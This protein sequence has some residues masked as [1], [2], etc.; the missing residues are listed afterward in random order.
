MRMKTSALS[1]LAAAIVC[2]CSPS[3]H[4]KAVHGY[5]A[6]HHHEAITRKRTAAVAAS[7]SPPVMS[8]HTANALRSA[9]IH[10]LFWGHSWHDTAAE[11]T[12]K[13][14]QG[15]LSEIVRSSYITQ[16]SN[17]D[18]DARVQIAPA[19]LVSSNTCS[20]P[21][22]AEGTIY[23]QNPPIEIPE[24]VIAPCIDENH[25]SVSHDD[26]FVLLLP[27]NVY[28]LNDVN[29]G[30]HL[31]YDRNLPNGE[32]ETFAYATIAWHKARGEG[33][34]S[35]SDTITH[36]TLEAITDPYQ[37]TIY[38]H[39]GDDPDDCDK[40]DDSPTC[41]IADVCESYP[42]AVSGTGVNYARWWDQRSSQCVVTAPSAR[43]SS[44]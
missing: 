34:D 33:F 18:N 38:G 15:A 24:N 20:Q 27:A 42:D 37:D 1:F 16:A 12:M 35:F 19:H 44:R 21:D 26:L 7:A 8:T 6:T 31:Y 4:M 2:A 17:Y 29:D 30:L 25:L 10:L 22:P 23:A 11:I 36:E 32:A 9:R 43:A 13:K 28:M 41:E 14:V 40:N 3:H 5:V 39:Y